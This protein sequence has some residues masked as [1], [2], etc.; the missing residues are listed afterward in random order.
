[1]TRR[2]AERTLT[3]TAAAVALGGVGILI[4]AGLAGMAVAPAQV[5]EWGILLAVPSCAR[6]AMFGMVPA[7]DL[8]TRAWQ[9]AASDLDGRRNGR[10]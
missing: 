9:A 1:M 5:I 7:E 2:Y 8:I 3:A 4:G 6:L 10:S